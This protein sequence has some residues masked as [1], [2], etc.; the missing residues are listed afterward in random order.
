MTP[1]AVQ[2]KTDASH[3]FLRLN[4]P[5]ADSEYPQPRIAEAGQTYTFPFHFV[6]PER[7]LP[8]ACTHDCATSHVHEAHVCLPPTMGDFDLSSDDLSP[9]M[10]K[11]SYVI[12]ARVI[13][14]G[15][16]DAKV[17]VLAKSSRKIRVMPVVPEAPPLHILADDREYALSATK[18]LRKGMF[19]GKLGRLTASAAQTKALLVSPTSNSPP[20]IMATVYLRFDPADP[21]A[22]PPRLGS[23]SSRIK[24]HTFYSVKPLPHLATRTS[25][26]ASYDITRGVY[27]TSIPLATRCVANVT[28]T[29][30]LGTPPN[31]V[32]RDSGYSTGSENANSN[33]NAASLTASNSASGPQRQQQRPRPEPISGVGYCNEAVTGGSGGESGTSYF[34]T[35]ILLPLTLPRGKTW[36]PTFHS[37]IVSRVYLLDV[38]LTVHSP[39]A[40][41]PSTTLSLH[42]PVQIST[43]PAESGA[44][45]SADPGLGLNAAGDGAGVE[46]YFV[47][48]VLDVPRAEFVGGSAGI[49]SGTS[50]G[51]LGS[52]GSMASAGD[53]EEPPG[54][55][56]LGSGQVTVRRAGTGMLG[57]LGR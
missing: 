47:P 31:Y 54:Y 7:L 30:R 9:A 26:I 22:A 51:Q 6:I 3:T 29:H 46:E 42:L 16:A 36:L 56:A 48:R 23:L 38:S 25:M 21:S 50:R 57:Q 8:S 52:I 1:V 28:W 44:S 32:R 5:I 12:K 34:E 39:G 40:G 45:G 11:I 19:K 49:L 13:R 37:C 4:M 17:V 35:T 18:T 10:A 53:G 15:E 41:V 33:S 43:S 27:T 20:T 24:A 55:E 2:T 14:I